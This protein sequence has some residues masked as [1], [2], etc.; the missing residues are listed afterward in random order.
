MKLARKH[1][2]I[3]L[4]YF[5]MIACLG[6][7]LRLFAV[8]DIPANYRFLVHTHS[9]IALLGWVYTA[10]ISLLMFLFCREKLVSKAY[11]RIFWFTQ[12]TIVGMLFTFPF[13]GYA[14]FS[15]IF[16]TLFLIASYFFAWFFFKST[17]AEKKSRNSYKLI[18]LAIWYMIISTIGPWSL[19]YI[20]TAFGNGSAWYR[21]AIYFYLHFQYNG[22]F[23]V[24]ITGIFL[25]LLEQKAFPMSRKLFQP[26]Y[27]LLNAG[28]LLSFLLSVLWMK[29]S[30]IYYVLAGAG[31]LMEI[32]AFILL[33]LHMMKKKVSEFFPPSTLFYLKIAG[34]LLVGKLFAQFAGAFPF[35]ANVVT[36][37]LDLVISYLHW[38]FLGI[39]SLTLLAF[40]DH[41][42]LLKFGTLSFVIFISGFILTEFLITY[43]GLSAIAKLPVIPD[44]SSYIVL[45]SCLLVIAIGRILFKQIAWLKKK[46]LHKHR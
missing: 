18:R 38:I 19:G 24:A 16:S 21:N 27:Y 44:I 45:A 1:I 6:L 14:L 10:I 32:L 28:V 3:G 4:L 46:K 37:N 41:N 43:R 11:R 29:P 8:I 9:H 13:T 22:W 33:F 40:L 42:R 15:I 2:F 20:I 12:F 36:V 30:G 26:F 35:I 34:V 23:L 25:Y 17:P 39:I 31:G 7:S 5:F